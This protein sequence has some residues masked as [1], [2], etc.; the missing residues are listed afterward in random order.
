L[1]NRNRWIFI[2]LPIMFLYCSYKTIGELYNRCKIT[3]YFGVLN[4][5]NNNTL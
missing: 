5:I 4:N 2:R 3:R 1:S